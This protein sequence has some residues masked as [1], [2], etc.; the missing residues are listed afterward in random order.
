[1]LKNK[2]II[3][4]FVLA[5]CLQLLGALGKINSEA[6]GGILLTAGLG[7]FMVCLGLALLKVLKSEKF[8]G[9]LER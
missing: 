3:S 1:M 8:K 4:G 7:L 9:F 6:W 2:Y 5:I